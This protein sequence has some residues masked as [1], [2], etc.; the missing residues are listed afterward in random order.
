MKA[1]FERILLDTDSHSF[2][3]DTEYYDK[4]TL[5][6]RMCSNGDDELVSLYFSLVSDDV[7]TMLLERRQSDDT[8]CIV[9][10]VRSNSVSVV[11]LLLSEH[12]V[13]HPQLAQTFDQLTVLEIARARGANAEMIALL[14]SYGAVEADRHSDHSPASNS[15]PS[16]THSRMSNLFGDSHEDVTDIDDLYSTHDNDEDDDVLFSSPRPPSYQLNSSFKRG[17]L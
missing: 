11:Q 10:A 17:E 1:I 13:C 15:R 14:K 12:E 6:S 8:T 2:P 3:H 7:A 5:L 16:S 4:Q 9:Q